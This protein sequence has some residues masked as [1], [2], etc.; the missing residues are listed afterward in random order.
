MNSEF[1]KFCK[2]AVRARRTCSILWAWHTS[3]VYLTRIV[4]VS[5][6]QGCSCQ[7]SNAYVKGIFLER[8]PCGFGSLVLTQDVV[9]WCSCSQSIKS[10][11]RTSKIFVEIF[12][13]TKFAK[14]RP[15][16]IVLYGSHV[17]MWLATT[18]STSQVSSC[19]CVSEIW[20]KQ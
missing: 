14:L 17:T 13:W 1:W 16:K 15:A 6:T 5:S 7:Q 20:F 11:C 19:G 4:P 12:S 9:H 2:F 8:V 10:V 18:W 3:L